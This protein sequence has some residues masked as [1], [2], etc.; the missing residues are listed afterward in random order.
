MKITTRFH[1][2]FGQKVFFFFDFVPIHFWSFTILIRSN[3]VCALYFFD[4][5]FFFVTKHSHQNRIT[6]KE[7]VTI[8]TLTS[9]HT[10]NTMKSFCRTFVICS[11]LLFLL[12]FF[13]FIIWFPC[14]CL[15]TL[16][17]K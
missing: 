3:S 14:Q 17:M 10:Q 9:T 11:Q 1:S 13:L 6:T 8:I 4:C 2:F 7:T 12:V 15:R 16:A 5:C